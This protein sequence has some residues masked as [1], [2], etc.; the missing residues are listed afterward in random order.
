M[1]WDIF[2]YR[3][4]CGKMFSAIKRGRI[5]GNYKKINVNQKKQ[6]EFDYEI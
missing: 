4:A 6:K 3:Q 5:R 1:L 2:T